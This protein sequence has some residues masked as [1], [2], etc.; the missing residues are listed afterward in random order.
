M[1]SAHGAARHISNHVC[2]ACAV[3]LQCVFSAQ[4]LVGAI[5]VACAVCLLYTWRVHSLRVCTACMSCVCSTYVCSTRALPR[6]RYAFGESGVQP[7][8]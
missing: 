2:V 6:V 5:C 7:V 8:L 3:C 4:R 1:M